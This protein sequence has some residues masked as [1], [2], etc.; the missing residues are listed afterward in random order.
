MYA[1]VRKNSFNF[2][3]HSGFHQGWQNCHEGTIVKNRAEAGTGVCTALTEVWPSLLLH[4]E[5]SLHPHVTAWRQKYIF[6][7]FIAVCR[8]LS[9]MLTEME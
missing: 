1:R 7:V 4:S 3:S 5:T 6:N 9:V 8:L 2:S